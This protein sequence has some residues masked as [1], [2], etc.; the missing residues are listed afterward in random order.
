MKL[1]ED[2]IALFNDG[3]DRCVADPKFLETFYQRFVEGSSRVAE[4]FAATD[5]RHQEKALKASLYTA[6]MAADDNR[7]A[8]DHLK[9]L[10]QRH[11]DLGI[12]PELYELWLE[13]LLAAAQESGALTDVRAPDVWRRVLGVAIR[14]MQSAPADTP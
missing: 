4:L 8:L 10:G 12:E 7:P 9:V 1:A 2:E 5:M 14:A 6:M 13:T 3:L 11:R